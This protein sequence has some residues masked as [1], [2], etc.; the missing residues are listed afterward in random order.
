M[1]IRSAVALA[2]FLLLAGAARPRQ[3]DGRAAAGAMLSGD[4]Q[5]PRAQGMS[6]ETGARDSSKLTVRMGFDGRCTGAL[7]EVWAVQRARACRPS[8]CATGASRPTCGRPSA[9]SA[10]CA[11]ARASSSGA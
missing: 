3:A 4:I 7:A 1:T 5:F 8:A 9:T 2:P 10:T 11:G 6:I